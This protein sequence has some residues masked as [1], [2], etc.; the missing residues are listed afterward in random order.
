MADE[1]TDVP[2]WRFWAV[3]LGAVALVGGGYWY[4][5]RPTYEQLVSAE[6]LAEMDLK[7]CG[8]APWPDCTIARA[9]YEKA[10]QRVLDAT[11]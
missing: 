8:T 9:R 4:S 7:Y 1:S 2:A 3:L 10:H 5:Q 6:K 11:P